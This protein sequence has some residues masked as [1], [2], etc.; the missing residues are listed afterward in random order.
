MT[1][2]DI[3]K[4]VTKDFKQYNIRDIKRVINIYMDD[5]YEAVL[6]NKKPFIKFGKIGYFYIPNTVLKTYTP[7]LLRSFKGAKTEEKKK[8]IYKKIM[9]MKKV[10][11]QKIDFYNDL[12]I[13]KKGYYERITNRLKRIINYLYIGLNQIKTFED[14][15]KG[16]D[17][18]DRLS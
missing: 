14:E 16:Y 6:E 9:Q 12:L 18:K 15:F 1:G 5:V 11:E 4:E 2:E 7:L 13:Y 10:Y 8:S 3:Y 17:S